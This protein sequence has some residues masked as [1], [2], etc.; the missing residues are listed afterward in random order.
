M[1]DVV[2]CDSTARVSTGRKGRTERLTGTITVDDA[3]LRFR[4]STLGH[5]RTLLVSREQI[6]FVAGDAPSDGGAT[7]RVTTKDGQMSEFALA[8]AN[9][10]HAARDLLSGS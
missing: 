7:L 9:D 10:A 8:T 2:E 3:G 4:Y 6:A 1:S 5:S